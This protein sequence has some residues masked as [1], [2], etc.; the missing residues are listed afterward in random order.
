MFNFLLNAKSSFKTSL[1]GFFSLLIGLY[2]GLA[3]H[4]WLMASPFIT[5]GFGFLLTKDSAVN[6][7]E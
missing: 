1:V 3:E 4:D 2:I 6:N 5:S 7:P